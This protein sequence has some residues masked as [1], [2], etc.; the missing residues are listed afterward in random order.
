MRVIFWEY[1]KVWEVVGGPQ[2]CRR[3]GWRFN[4]G[5][6]K[7][8]RHVQLRI[9]ANDDNV[10]SSDE[11]PHLDRADDRLETIGLSLIEIRAVL[12]GSRNAW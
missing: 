5:T 12:A 9:V 6:F 1:G 11:I 10:L 8:G 3:M 7:T 4:S 2:R